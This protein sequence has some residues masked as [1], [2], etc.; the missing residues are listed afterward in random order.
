MDEEIERIKKLQPGQE[1][2]FGKIKNPRLKNLKEALKGFLEECNEEEIG[3]GFKGGFLEEEIEIGVEGDFLGFNRL[4]FKIRE[5][6]L[7]VKRP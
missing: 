2:K 1:V 4:E 6:D 5:G 3:V 7:V